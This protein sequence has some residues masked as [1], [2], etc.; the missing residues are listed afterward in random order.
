MNINRRSL[1]RGVTASVFG[2]PFV[3]GAAGKSRHWDET[4]DVV[5]V[6]YGGAGNLR[7]D[8]CLCPRLYD[9]IFPRKRVSVRND[10]IL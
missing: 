5:V 10:E 6:G 9:E 7:F 3:A 8:S 4:F 1:I 2:L